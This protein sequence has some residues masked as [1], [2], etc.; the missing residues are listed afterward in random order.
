VLSCVHVIKIFCG[1]TKDKTETIYWKVIKLVVLY[2]SEFCALSS[3][4]ENTL[5]I[6]ERKILRTVF[7]SVKGNGEWRICSYQELLDLCR[8]PD[9]NIR[10]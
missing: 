8:E 4:D 5:T 6:W 3:G 7:G 2:S 9:I 1:L 10:N